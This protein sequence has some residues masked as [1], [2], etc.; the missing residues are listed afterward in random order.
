MAVIIRWWTG[1]GGCVRGRRIGRFC[2]WTVFVGPTLASSRGRIVDLM[3]P[4]D[5]PTCAWISWPLLEVVFGLDFSLIVFRIVRGDSNFAFQ[6]AFNGRLRLEAEPRA[7]QG[8][9]LPHVSTCW[10]RIAATQRRR[11][12]RPP[13]AEVLAFVGPL[14]PR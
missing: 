11:L 2:G 14:W 7:P 9:F 10:D 13:G 6:L 5:W 12:A 4:C 1:P 8:R 3:S